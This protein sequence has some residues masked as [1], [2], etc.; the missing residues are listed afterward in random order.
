METR[1]DGITLNKLESL[2]LIPWVA[3]RPDGYYFVANPLEINAPPAIV[4]DLVKSVS[5]YNHFSNGSITVTLPQGELKVDNA[6]HF[7]LYKHQPI[8]TL[9][10]DSD[11][12]ISVVDDQN[13]IVAWERTI[14]F[15][16][17]TE[18]YRVLEPLDEGRKTRSHIALKIPGFAGFFTNKMLKQPIEGAFNDVNEGIRRAAEEKRLGL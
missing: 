10:P 17:T 1:N 7:A 3:G 12:I 15:S 5:Q 11:E 6:I 14:P 16:G 18:C 13:Y 8:G 4:W 2:K 9:I